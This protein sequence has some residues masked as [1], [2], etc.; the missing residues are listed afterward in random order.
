ML[1]NRKIRGILGLLLIW[2]LIVPT[3]YQAFAGNSE[4]EALEEQLAPAKVIAHSKGKTRKEKE[5]A[6]SKLLEFAKTAEVKPQEYSTYIVRLEAPAVPE[7]KGGIQDLKPTSPLVTKQKKLD[8][9]RAESQAY[10]KYLDLERETVVKKV[11]HTI[12]RQPKIVHEYR[13]DLQSN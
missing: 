6:V 11:H 5:P 12:G 3:Y 13:L 9:K 10:M 1:K 7:Y 8:V 4:Q 2:T